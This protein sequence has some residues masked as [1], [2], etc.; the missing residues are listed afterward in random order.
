MPGRVIATLP[1][2]QWVDSLKVEEGGR[3]CV[4][5]IFNGG[6]T[7]FSPDGHTEHV[8]VPDLF[9]T[10]LC[11]G[12]EDMQEVFITASS[13]GTILKTRWPRPGLRLAFNA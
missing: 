12:G 5:M 8:E 7:V 9:T 13:T 11:F 10:N 4:G 2:F 1:G 6:I 3:V